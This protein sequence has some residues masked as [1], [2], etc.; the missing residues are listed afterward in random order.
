MSMGDPEL[1]IVVPM[2][3]E[4]E[5]CGVFFDTVV[6]ILEKAV[7]SFEIICIND[8]SQDDTLLALYQHNLSDARNKSCESLP[9]FWKRICPHSRY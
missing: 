8:G 5:S 1:S 4:Q 9:K 6:P 3:N 7:S 2:Y